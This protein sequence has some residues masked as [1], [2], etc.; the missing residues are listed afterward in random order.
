MKLGAAAGIL[1]AMLAWESLSPRRPWSRPRLARRA[2]NVALGVINGALVRL[3]LGGAAASAAAYAA[4]R[5]WGALAL[6]EWPGW[7]EGA[8]AIAAL[9]LAVY[10]QHVVFHKVPALWRLHRVHHTDLD[11]DTTTGLRFHPVEILLSALYKGAIAVALGAP[12]WAVVAFEAILNG[13]SLFNHGNVGIP[14]GADRVIRLAIVT[15]DMHRIHHSNLRHETDSNYGFSVPFWDRLFGTY[16]DAPGMG[17][18][19]MALGVKGYEDPARVRFARL[20]IQ[21]LER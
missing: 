20:F 10:A 15:P 3:A 4:A 17:W 9:D 16:R 8:L 21:P 11:V 1:V 18:D 14:A 7:A 2:G 5:G 12:A 19:G 13:A 6:V